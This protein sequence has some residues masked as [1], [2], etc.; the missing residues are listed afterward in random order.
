[1]CFLQYIILPSYIIFIFGHHPL[2]PP[3]KVPHSAGCKI[4]GD[5][6]CNILSC[7][8]VPTAT[9]LQLCAYA[10]I[11]HVMCFCF[12]LRKAFKVAGLS[13]IVSCRPTCT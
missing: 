4:S 6:T 8:S 7:C 10:L 2:F 5:V 9:L 1:M 11:L 13:H 12:V 3:C